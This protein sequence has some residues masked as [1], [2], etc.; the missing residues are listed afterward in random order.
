MPWARLQNTLLL[1]L[2]SKRCAVGFLHVRGVWVRQVSFSGETVQMGL[3]IL[4]LIVLPQMI[5]V[6]LFFE[7]PGSSTHWVWRGNGGQPIGVF[8]G[9]T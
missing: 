1:S 5:M 9:R 3:V 8:F 4:T 2:Y 7:F 6:P